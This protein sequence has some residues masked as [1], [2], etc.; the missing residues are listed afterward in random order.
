MALCTLLPLSWLGQSSSALF[1]LSSQT[2]KQGEEKEKVVFMASSDYSQSFF[3]I[4]VNATATVSLPDCNC[5]FMTLELHAA[6]SFAPQGR[7]SLS[8]LQAFPFPYPFQS[9]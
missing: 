6:W 5:S 2:W 7:T 3:I 1:L 4:V 9:A 8:F